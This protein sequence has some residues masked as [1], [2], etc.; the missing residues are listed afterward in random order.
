MLALQ[1]ICPVN[2]HRTYV[3]NLKNKIKFFEI[4]LFC[5]KAHIGVIGNERADILAKMGTNKETMDAKFHYTKAQVRK[6]LYKKYQRVWN[7]RWCESLSGRTTY[8]YFK[9]VSYKKIVSDFFLNQVVT[10]HGIFPS[11]Q[12]ERFGRDDMCI[13]TNAKG[14]IDHIIKDCHLGEQIRKEYFGPDYYNKD[15]KDLLSHRKSSLGLRLIIQTYYELAMSSHG[16]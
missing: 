2:E 1:A 8:N 3:L 11:F 14:T 16:T 5:T 9:D 12:A 7:N 6:S 13:C 15:M 4:D 10:G